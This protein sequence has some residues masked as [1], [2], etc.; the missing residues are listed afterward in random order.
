MRRGLAL[1]LPLALAAL[2]LQ[3]SAA[4]AGC[5]SGAAH[6]SELEQVA[7]G[8]LPVF[9]TGV[10]CLGLGR[11][12]GLSI[13]WAT[14]AGARRLARQRR[15][16]LLGR[17]KRACAL[18]FFRGEYWSSRECARL[19]ADHGVRRLGKLDTFTLLGRLYPNGIR[20]LHLAAL[21]DRRAVPLLLARFS[22]TRVC[23]LHRRPSGRPG[24]RCT[25]YSE[26]AL[27]R[28]PRRRRSHRKHRLTVLN[29]LWHLAAGPTLA[30]LERL[31]Q[32]EP[33]KKVRLRAAR[34]LSRVRQRSLKP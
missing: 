18:I 15:S 8:G 5:G 4:L 10:R 12:S 26:G 31:A 9:Q 7:R 3:P 22:A 20:P 25:N 11:H 14:P 1:T 33:D 13:R 16:R 2:W 23:R 28:S 34:V 30:F 29:A 27:R 21:G 19:L 24:R 17:I 6:V 32:S